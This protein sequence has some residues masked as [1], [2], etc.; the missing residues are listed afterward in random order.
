ME[1]VQPGHSLTP[2]WLSQP[3]STVRRHKE[4]THGDITMRNRGEKKRNKVGS[5][6]VV[7]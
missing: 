7:K 3:W 2:V 1:E 4:K 6:K 5:F